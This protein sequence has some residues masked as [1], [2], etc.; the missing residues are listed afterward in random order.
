MSNFLINIFVL[1]SFI[2]FSICGLY[3]AGESARYYIA[4]GHE[5][6]AI[7][8]DVVLIFFGIVLIVALLIKRDNI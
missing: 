5:N 6:Y 7:L 2:I 3:L 1:I 4:N 8:K